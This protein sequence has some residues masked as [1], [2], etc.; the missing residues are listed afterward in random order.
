[1]IGFNGSRRGVLKVLRSVMALE[2]GFYLF[3][4]YWSEI[5][6]FHASIVITLINFSFFIKNLVAM[7]MTVNIT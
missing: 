4:C 1:M 2:E 6:P 5:I 7:Q 3:K